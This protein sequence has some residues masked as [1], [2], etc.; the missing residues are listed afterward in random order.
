MSSS[1]TRA[2]G[3]AAALLALLLVTAPALAATPDPDPIRDWQRVAVRDAY[4]VRSTSATTAM[5]FT[6]TRRA[7][8]PALS[9]TYATHDGSALAG[10]D[11]TA[12][13]GSVAFVAGETSTT[14]AV[15]VLARASG[16]DDR[17]F[18][19]TL[20]DPVGDI[21]DFE[22]ARAT[23][24]IANRGASSGLDAD[25]ACDGGLYDIVVR[26]GERIV[27]CL[28]AVRAPYA[29]FGDR[30]VT[31][32]PLAG[33]ATFLL[34]RENGGA[35]AWIRYET[36]D[37]TAR[38]G[39]DYVATS[40]TI[41]LSAMRLR[42]YVTVPVDPAA[43]ADGDR[44]FSLRIAND[45]TP[46]PPN[47]PALVATI[48][49]ATPLAPAIARVGRPLDGS[50][51]ADA[52]ARRWERCNADGGCTTIAG[53]S[54]ASYEPT[55]A[56]VG[57]WLRVRAT[58]AGAVGGPDL[59]LATPPTAPVRAL[60]AAPA[61]AG[62][63]AEGMESDATRVTFALAG[64]EDDAAYE[65][66][67]DSAEFE[68][69]GAAADGYASDAG[70][71]T[72]TL[73]GLAPGAHSFAVRQ[74]TVDGLVSPASARAWTVRVRASAPPRAGPRAEPPRTDPPTP[75]P[76]R[77]DPPPAARVSGRRQQNRDVR[78]VVAGRTNVVL[79]CAAPCVLRTPLTVSA[80]AARRLGLR[81][82]R[83]GTASGSSR[84]AGLVRLRV[85]LDAAA[86]GRLLR[87]GRPVTLVARLEDA[88]VVVRFRLLPR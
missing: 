87:I 43:L 26:D 76:P 53:E 83:V 34:E 86:R 35:P 59:L 78:A 72:V 15:P 10:T 3:L 11:Y 17:T 14:V 20:G 62:G 24:T 23:G 28:G 1:R 37:G 8:G 68:P 30:S 80:A 49:H 44:T 33:T 31:V 41:K 82:T 32:D 13:T 16:G 63:P 71:T 55:A 45:G 67:L 51:A 36:V 6:V 7:A 47:D 85:R 88:A 27:R 84:A 57:L 74:R 42:A 9:L 69:C 2:T 25:W 39:V 66:A 70:T 60:P 52:S 61:L 79:R 50:A 46:N 22:R 5:S 77:D 21:A 48:R 19:L 73:D 38:A 18:T 29:Q 4:A 65:C 40:G 81:T 56:D 64:K 58:V 54:G 12:A 75:A